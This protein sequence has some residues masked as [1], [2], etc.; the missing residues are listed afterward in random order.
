MRIKRIISIILAAA[1]TISA[2]TF[3]MA[4]AD[5]SDTNT[6]ASTSAGKT[7]NSIVISG[8]TDI[9]LVRSSVMDTLIGTYTE[10]FDQRS[11]YCDDVLN[12]AD[13]IY[14]TE[15]ARIRNATDINELVQADPYTE[16]T[17]NYHQD[18]MDAI[19]ELYM[20]S[21]L[22]IEL[23]VESSDDIPGLVSNLRNTYLGIMD[24]LSKE[25]Y[26]D[27]YWQIITDTKKEI[28]TATEDI[29]TFKE[30][31]DA[32]EYL[33][34]I[35]ADG[36]EVSLDDAF[37]ELSTDPSAIQRYI[38]SGRY[39]SNYALSQACSTFKDS[40]DNYVDIV[41]LG[42]DTGCTRKSLESIV[43]K[44]VK[45]MNSRDVMTE[46]Y[47]A[48]ESGLDD[49]AEATGVSMDDIT[50]VSIRQTKKF[51][52]KL[53]KYYSSLKRSS[54]YSAQ[55]EK[56]GSIYTEYMDLSETYNITDLLS[57]NLLAEFKARVKKIKTKAQL[58]KRTYRI[59][60]KKYGN[61]TVSPSKRVRYGKSYTV[62]VKPA[63]GHTLKR[64]VIDGIQQKKKSSY[65]FKKVKKNHT[66]KVYFK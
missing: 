4:F 43:S 60:V 48:Y 29:T 28:K 55:W 8:D 24:M 66:I 15:Y 49:I 46:V 9:E 45:R 18:T 23:G 3:S 52:K 27:Y 59:T 1:V 30:Y 20:L 10:C 25:D 22:T 16:L 54:Y 50:S 42:Y 64:V 32:S 7:I 11:L 36:D 53:Q 2:C 44:T 19:N 35:T 21:E 51:Q 17:F 37:Y 5:T 56:I 12:E 26:N 33:V 38:D 61:G 6:T 58:N 39:Y 31:A 62:R 41:L 63:K 34:E 57:K 14:N 40:M 65:K 47:Q 13:E